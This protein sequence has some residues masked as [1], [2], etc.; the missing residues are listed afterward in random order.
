MILGIKT[1]TKSHFVMLPLNY[2]ILTK[3]SLGWSHFLLL[4]RYHGYIV[5]YCNYQWLLSG[6]WLCI[7]IFSP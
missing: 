2:H 3:C 5:T 4:R 7:I 1:D 6:Q